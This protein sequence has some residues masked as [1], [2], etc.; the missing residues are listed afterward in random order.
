MSVCI[1]AW[2]EGH[3]DTDDGEGWFE[4]NSP[5]R[6]KCQNCLEQDNQGTDT[7]GNLVQYDDDGNEIQVAA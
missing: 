4:L 6:F 1:C 5:F 7:S 2:C 3:S